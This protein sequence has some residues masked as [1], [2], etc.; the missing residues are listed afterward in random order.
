M[1]HKKITKN[2]LFHIFKLKSATS[3]FHLKQNL[4]M[5]SLTWAVI[6]WIVFFKFN[7]LYHTNLLVNINIM[8]KRLAQPCGFIASGFI[9]FLNEH[10]LD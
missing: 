1:Y 10:E 2:E 8:S 7:Q 4:L 6:G 3:V 9:Y 5:L